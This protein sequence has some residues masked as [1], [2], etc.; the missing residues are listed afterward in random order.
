MTY[1]I[2]TDRYPGVSYE[3]WWGDV[4][5][6]SF[7][8]T[9]HGA[10]TREATVCAPA[11]TVTYPGARPVVTVMHG[12]GQDESNMR[13]LIAAL[14]G[15]GYIAAT[16]TNQVD[17]SPQPQNNKALLDWIASGSNPYL[18]R[19]DMS[20]VGV[21]GHSAGG[22]AAVL[23]Q[24]TSRGDAYDSRVDS[25]V[26]LDNLHK[27]RFGGDQS[28]PG[29]PCDPDSGYDPYV[30][31]KPSLGL[32]SDT[33]CASRPSYVPSDLKLSGVRHWK[34]SSIASGCLVMKGFAH[35]DFTSTGTEAKRKR[36]WWV[37][38]AWLDR[39]VAGVGAALD[40]LYSHTWNGESRSTVLSD[41]YS[42]VIEDKFLLHHPSYL[43]VGGTV[44]T[45]GGTPLLGD[46]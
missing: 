34:A 44:L 21:V 15:H 7:T 16:F 14:A 27:F 13:W 36:V 24:D 12:T 17:M 18:A 33:Y 43:T 3:S 26:Y 31:V 40:P 22:D 5:G 8:Y 11:D 38:Q 28:Q 41:D 25:V 20:K 10:L 4:V 32:A 37:V 39:Y 9:G 1:S 35:G 45:R 2:T 23:T 6:L 46:D 29:S 19:T 42:S 30:P